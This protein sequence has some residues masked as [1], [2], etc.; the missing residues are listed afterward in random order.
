MRVARDFAEATIPDTSLI[1]RGPLLRPV[2]ASDDWPCANS[3][4]HH[5]NVVSVQELEPINKCPVR[6]VIA[7]IQ[8]YP[9]HAAGTSVLSNAARRPEG[10][11]GTSHSIND[12][13]SPLF[14]VAREIPLT[15][16]ENV[17]DHLCELGGTLSGAEAFIAHEGENILWSA[18]RR[19]LQPSI[20]RSEDGPLAHRPV[21]IP[22]VI[23]EELG[24]F[25]AGVESVKPELHVVESATRIARAAVKY[26][27]QPDIVTDVDGEISF[28]IRLNNGRLIMAEMS[29]GGSI[30]A[31][32]YDDRDEL[33]RRMPKATEKEFI[34][35]LKS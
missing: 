7:V 16:A 15:S 5:D 8:S 19:Q 3:A 21:G 17:A 35:V 14:L 18:R 9:S 20:V 27:P 32:I 12:V 24:E 10:T 31:S 34:E 6:V 23:Q 29:V 26:T 22:R 25:G 33:L 4:F 2:A 13:D 1:C 30:D 11:W 28:Y